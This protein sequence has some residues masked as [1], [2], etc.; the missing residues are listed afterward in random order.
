MSCVLSFACCQSKQIR[1]A[2][3]IEFFLLG[4]HFQFD[5]KYEK[6]NPHYVLYYLTKI[7]RKKDGKIKS[8]TDIRKYKDAIM[9]GAEMKNQL[10]PLTFYSQIENFEGSYKK[11]VSNERSKGNVEK[12]TCNPIPYTLYHLVLN[13]ALDANNIFVW[14]WTL[15]QWHCMA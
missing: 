3:S 2:R 13:W 7:K 10:L 6:L 14:F 15:C 5:L 8:V 12:E 9:W 1:S 11:E 4:V